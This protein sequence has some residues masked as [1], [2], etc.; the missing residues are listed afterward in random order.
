MDSLAGYVA[1]SKRGGAAGEMIVREG[2]SWAL[3]ELGFQVDVADSDEAMEE[4]TAGAAGAAYSLY[5]FDQWTVMDRASRLRGFLVGREKVLFVLA[6]FGWSPAAAGLAA[7]AQ[8][9]VLTPYPDDRGATF[10]G[11]LVDPN[12]DAEAAWVLRALAAA[13]ATEGAGAD[14][15]TG[16]G[17]ATKRRVGVVWGKRRE[18]FEGREAM[19]SELAASPVL[20]LDELH[21][22]AGKGAARPLSAAAPSV[23]YHDALSRAEWRALLARSRFLLGL[24]NP[25]LGPSALDALAA[26]CL[27]I[28]PSHDGR[29][30]RPLTGDVGTHWVSQHPYLRSNVG[31]PH[32]C[33][34]VDVTRFEKGGVR[35]CVERALA[36]ELPPYVV[37]AFTKPQLLL[38]VR[39]ILERHDL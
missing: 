38:R 4:M 37:E 31:A 29:G 26:G 36:Q 25:L 27:Y 16:A 2:L 20:A 7:I 14:M 13:N 34:V 22:V 12:R 19:L 6:F 11:F 23:V 3:Q 1:G 5:F 30:T 17:A 15:R 9:N 32:V 18:Y 28:D 35:A 8:A 10:L 21:I 33:E 39:G 24:G